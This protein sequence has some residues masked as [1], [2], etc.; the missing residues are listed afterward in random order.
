MDCREE[1]AVSDGPNEFFERPCCYD[2]RIDWPGRLGRELP[3]LRELFGPPAGRRILDAGCGPG[4]HAVALAEAGY[5][6]TGADAEASMIEIAREHAAQSGQS[7]QWTVSAYHQLPRRAPGPYDGCYCIGNSL[8]A[9]GTPAR[10]K[11]SLRAIADVL[12]PGGVLFIQ[13]LNFPLLRQQE[14]CVRGLRAY[15]VDGKPCFSLK[16]FHFQRQTAHVTGITLYND[17]TWKHHARTGKL[18]AMSPDE[19]VAWAEAAGL[20]AQ[21]RFGDYRQSPFDPESS[22]DFIMVAEKRA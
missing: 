6:V 3:V 14:P 4:R 18:C 1:P 2:A 17:G 16:V 22:Q 20:S 19:L 8:A 12:V 5:D 9:A 15:E 21:S 11:A 7:V 10:V 13:V